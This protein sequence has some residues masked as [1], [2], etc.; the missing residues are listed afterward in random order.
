M[1]EFLHIVPDA[2]VMIFILWMGNKLLN[3]SKE[4][5]RK[6]DKRFEEVDKRIAGAEKIL[7]QLTVLNHRL[8]SIEEILK[9]IT[10]VAVVTEE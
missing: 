2:I 8:Q 10:R 4:H 7:S 9:K 3:D 6:V 5:A 1:T